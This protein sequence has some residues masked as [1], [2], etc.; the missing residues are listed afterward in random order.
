[1]RELHTDLLIENIKEMCV[2]ANLELADDVSSRIICAAQNEETELGKYGPYKQSQRGE[3]YKAYAKYL[4]DESG[5]TVFKYVL[6][7]VSFI[8]LNSS[9]NSAHA[10][11][12]LLS[13]G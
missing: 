10:V 2:E 9:S 5:P 4:L 11:A 7:R 1:M 12:I 13:Q 8:A 6:A 3:I